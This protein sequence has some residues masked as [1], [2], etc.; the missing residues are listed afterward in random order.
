[1]L[2]MNAH[3][4]DSTGLHIVT[5]FA[6]EGTLR[7]LID[8]LREDKLELTEDEAFYYFIQI[9]QAVHFLHRNGV[10]HCGISPHNILISQESSLKLDLIGAGL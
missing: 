2:N 9:A 5:E 1:M 4:E 3:F 10:T 8:E 7:S 6:G